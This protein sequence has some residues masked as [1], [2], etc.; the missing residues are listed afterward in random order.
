MKYAL[1]GLPC[2]GKTTMLGGASLPVVH[3]SAELDR[4]AGGCFS[5]LSEREKHSLRVLYAEQLSARED[6]FISDGHYSFPEGVVFTE[7]DGELYDVFIYLYCEPDVICERLQSSQKN[8]RYEGLSPERIRRWQREDMEGLRAECHKRGKD[9]YVL[10]GG[11]SAADLRCLTDKT[12]EGFGSCDMAR[13]IADRITEMFPEPCELCICDGDRTV[14]TQ[15]SFRVCTGGYETRVFDGS[16]YTGYQSLR[17]TE[18]VSKLRYD[19]DKLGGITLND[20]VYGMIADKDYVVLSSGITELWERL[21]TRLG[22][23]NVIADTLISADSKYCAVK[24]LQERGYT[25]TAFGDSKNDLYM[26]KQADTGY[27]YIGGGLS[28]SL[29][30]DDVSG[31]RLLCDKTPYI[32]A[33]ES[34]DPD[35]AADIGICRSDSGICG[36]RLADAHLRLGRRLGGVIRG[37]VPHTDT[38]VIVLE[39]GGRFFGDGLYAAFGGTFYSYDPKRDELPEF[40]HSAAVIV[41]S[42]INTGKS[43][44]TLTDRIRERCPRTE[45][46]IA[47]NVVRKEAAELF[48]EYKLFAVRTSANSFIGSRQAVQ[49]DG[50]G[51]DTADRL[52]NYIDKQRP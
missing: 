31:L 43:V 25:I 14:I 29:T 26:L 44:F 19:T 3:G 24:L 50:R 47:A 21:G 33:E 35:I 34:P 11:S 38:A 2:A 41:D 18:E 49:R 45:I 15:D 32:L 13:R 48:G 23:R 46:F 5:K 17:F 36:S 6:S 9:F 40:S 42:V 39:R 20:T 28:R 7:A 10:P 12:A 16:F 4:M 27:L 37:F 22:L 8:S 1:Y 51:P 30:E 52:F